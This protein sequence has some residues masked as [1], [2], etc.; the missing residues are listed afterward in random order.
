M[1][2]TMTGNFHGFYLDKSL[3]LLGFMQLAQQEENVYG[4]YM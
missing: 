4:T 1:G 3:H 2:I